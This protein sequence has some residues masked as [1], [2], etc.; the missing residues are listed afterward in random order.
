M[1][2]GDDIL[3]WLVLAVGGAL[4]VGTTLAL[5]RPRFDEE[6]EELPRPP[7]GRSVAMIALGTFAS[8]WALASLIS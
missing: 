3:P 2:L 5:F 8:L 4:A 7:L 6:G 1:L